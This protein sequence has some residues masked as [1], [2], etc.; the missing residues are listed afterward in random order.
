LAERLYSNVAQRQFFDLDPLVRVRDVTAIRS[1]LAELGYEPA[2]HLTQA[3]ERAYIKSGYEYTFDS[4]QGRNLV[5]IKWQVLPRFYSIG[6]KVD[7]FFERA[8][9][10][11]VAGHRV[12]T[13]CDQDLMLVLY[14]HAAKHGWRQISWLCD[15]TQLARSRALD[16]KALREQAE[17]L[18]ITRIVA[19]SFLLSHKFIARNG[20]ASA[21]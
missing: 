21:V 4:A 10:I 3:A 19:V 12:R 9:E 11:D 20:V 6:F 13:L 17:K 18:G 16:W 2:L 5:E 1:A 15:I 14:V 7:N 8:V